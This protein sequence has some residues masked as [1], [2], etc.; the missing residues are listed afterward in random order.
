MC[1][2]TTHLPCGRSGRGLCDILPITVDRLGSFAEGFVVV[3][4]DERGGTILLL[5]GGTAVGKVLKLALKV[6]EK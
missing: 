1:Y 3:E 4:C 2:N 5:V 6:V